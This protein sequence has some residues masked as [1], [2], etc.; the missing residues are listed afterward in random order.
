MKYF[1]VTNYKKHL[2][3]GDEV[4]VEITDRVRPIEG[5]IYRTN[6][7]SLY[8]C[9]NSRTLDGAD[10]PDKMGFKYSWVIINPDDVYDIL[11]IEVVGR[12]EEDDYEVF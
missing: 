10:S 9:T 3:N 11:S 12:K 4:L 8:L 1:N 7:N 5:K 2:K 6:K